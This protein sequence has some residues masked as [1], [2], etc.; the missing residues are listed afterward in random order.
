MYPLSPLPYEHDALQPVIGAETMQTHHGKH[1][2]KYVEVVNELIGEAAGARP[3][4]DVIAEAHE[5]GDHKLF[6]NAA[7]TWNHGFFWESMAPNET[8]PAEALQAAIDST[9]GNSGALKD[10]FV[11]E[12]AAHFGSGWV[13]LVVSNGK[14]EVVSTHDAELPWLDGRTPLLVCDVWEHAYYLDYKNERDRFLRAWFDRLANWDF[15]A[16][17]HA[18]ALRGEAGYRYPLAGDV[19]GRPS[20]RHVERPRSAPR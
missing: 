16:E 6:N 1:H 18:A 2:A 17:Q 14:L 20:A 10:L 9:F 12:G 7:Q 5:R 13:W 4:E 11:R 15:A 3:L 19:G 8:E